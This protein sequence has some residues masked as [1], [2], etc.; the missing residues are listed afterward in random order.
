VRV[1]N[2]VTQASVDCDIVDVGPWNTNDPYWQNGARPQAES[3]FNTSG[4]PTN[5]AG[6]DL[7]PA[8]A[9]AI[10]IDGK[11]KVDWE[12]V[13][14]AETTPEGG[15]LAMPV[16]NIGAFLQQL[17]T[18]VQTLQQAKQ[19]QQG[20]AQPS[21]GSSQPAQIDLQQ[22]ITIINA[23]LSSIGKP[24]LGPVNGALGT[25]IGN[26]LNGKKTAIGVIGTVLTAIM[27]SPQISAAITGA[28]PALAATPVSAVLWPVFLALTGWG[29]LGK[30]E[31]W[32][33]TVAQS[34]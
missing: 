5:L 19:P 16:N 30:M 27:S 29:V 17:I 6:I 25:A 11:G 1:T 9:R 32:S 14:A 3:G 7:T 33:Q 21:G 4:K 10:G 28:I 22:I 23:I 34:Q 12:F 2:S 26:A 15:K 13:G 18:A 31:K 20:N 8:A 24:P